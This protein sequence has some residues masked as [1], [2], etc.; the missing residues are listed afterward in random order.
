MSGVTL[1]ERLI[2]TC[3][4]NSNNKA[5]ADS[6]GASLTFGEAFAKALFLTG[7][8]GPIFAEQPKV[9]IL[10]PPSVGGALVNWAVL[11]MGKIPVNLNYTLSQEG[12]ISCLEQCGI[13]DVVVS[14]KLME[15]LK[16]DLPVRVHTLEDLATAPRLTEKLR[17]GFLAKCTSSK[18][19]LKRLGGSQVGQDDLATII[20]SSG[21]TGQPKGVMLSHRNIITNVEQVAE[22]YSFLPKDCMLGVLPFFHSFGFMATIAGPAIAGFGCAYHFN[23]I[24]S[25]VI[26]PLAEE[27]E[28]SIMIATPT[29]LQFYLPEKYQ[30]LLQQDVQ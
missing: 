27:N 11:L 12:I 20:F 14:G 15:R 10:V 13:T 19:L 6:S 25:K 1:Q 24:E 28:V 5:L 17:A 21:S 2:R 29:F 16:L 30:Q 9:G 8:L 23:P 22:V 18:G 26:G 7:R 4:E 3:R